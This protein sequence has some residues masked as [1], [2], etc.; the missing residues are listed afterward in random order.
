MT[1]GVGSFRSRK[2]AVDFFSNIFWQ[3]LT[4]IFVK[5]SR[6][7]AG[8]RK[9]NIAP[10]FR[11]F[12]GLHSKIENSCRPIRA[13]EKTL[14]YCKIYYHNSGH[15]AINI[16]IYFI[17]INALVIITTGF[18]QHRIGKLR[19]LSWETEV[20][21]VVAKSHLVTVNASQLSELMLRWSLIDYYVPHQNS[22][23][24]WVL[25]EWTGRCGLPF[26]GPV[27]FWWLSQ[28]EGFFSFLVSCQ[29]Q[30]PPTYTRVCQSVQFERSR[31]ALVSWNLLGLSYHF[32]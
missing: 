32:P 10:P 24:N 2:N 19:E 14:R 23:N 18:D 4:F 5:V 17:S 29:K 26:R 3:L 16:P 21:M 20:V 7:L 6:T 22:L 27:R 15:F 13:F 9:G 8:E 28:S 12:H 11:L 1:L 25:N 31:A 30:H